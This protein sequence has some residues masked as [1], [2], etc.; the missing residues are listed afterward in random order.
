MIIMKMR[1]DYHIGANSIVYHM[2]I[3]IL[4]DLVLFKDDK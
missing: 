4:T 2:I 1:V 3:T